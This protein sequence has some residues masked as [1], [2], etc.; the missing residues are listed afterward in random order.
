MKSDLVIPEKGYEKGIT[1]QSKITV[2]GSRLPDIN[3]LEVTLG[4]CN[5]EVLSSP[6]PSA[7][8]FVCQ[9]APDCSLPSVGIKKELKVNVINFGFPQ[10]MLSQ[11]NLEFFFLPSIQGM[12]PQIGSTAGFTPVTI[13]GTGLQ[14]ITS[15]RFSNIECWGLNIIDD[16]KIECLTPKTSTG[17]LTI[18][19]GN[20]Y[21]GICDITGSN[22]K[23]FF[24]YSPGSTPKVTIVSP[25]SIDTT[26]PTTVTLTGE[27]FGTVS[28]DVT[29]AI[30]GEECTVTSLTG[31]DTIECTI[32]GLP[33]GKNF[34]D[35]R[36]S[37]LGKAST[38]SEV[39]GVEVVNDPVTP[40]EGSIYGGA[41]LTITGHGFH[42]DGMSAT[43]DGNSCEIEEEVTLSQILCEIPP[44]SAGTVPV[45]V[46]VDGDTMNFPAMNFVYSDTLSIT[47]VSPV[48]GAAGDLIT[49]TGSGFGTDENELSMDFDEAACVVQAGVSDTS[50]TCQ[51]GSH[52]LG[53]VDVVVHK[54]GYGLSNTL[55]PG[56]TYVPRL[57]SIHPD[58]GI[59]SRR[60]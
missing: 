12:T 29:V 8:Q 19:V 49:V 56:F 40:S 46:M 37:G 23:C 59:V 16:T 57:D 42:R 24:T 48:T 34:V 41:V 18:S 36:V 3:N 60:N 51:L 11:N 10:N 22:S 1:T 43:V 14:N 53:P 6:A 7:S 52:S 54:K 45:R 21:P 55:T 33:A 44:H 35:V 20:A 5:C 47:S 26:D 58:S 32:N 15:V 17:P 50:L 2:L 4:D 13:T 30:G 9:P 31:G 38:T 39:T 25:T 27:K 28:A